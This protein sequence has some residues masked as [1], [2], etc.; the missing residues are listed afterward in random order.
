MS[1]RP[2]LSRELV[3]SIVLADGTGI[4][5]PPVETL[6]LPEKVVQFGTG[7]FLRGFAEYFIDEANRRGMFGGSVVAVS[8]TG[9][10]RDALL[11]EQ[12]G[13]YT[14]AIQGVEGSTS[15]QRY[16]IIGSLSRAVSARDDWSA[17]LELARSPDTQLV[18]SNSTEVGIVLDESDTFDANPP[19]SFPGK[20]TRFLAERARTFDYDERRGL[21]VLPCELIEDNGDVLRAIVAKLARRWS[22]GARFEQWLRG[23]VVFC[24]T[25]VDRIVPGVV[26][27]RESDRIGRLFGYRDG[28]ITACE[29]YALFAIQGDDRLRARLGFA[30]A[31][32]RIVVVPDIGPYRERKVRVLNGAHTISVPVAL[33]SGL[34]TVRDAVEDERVG[35]FIRRVVLDDIV[36]SLDAPG[37]EEFA[38]EVLERFANPYIRHSLID[39]TLYGTTKMRVRVVPSIVDYYRRVGRAPASLAFGFAAYI[40]FMRG[41]VHAERRTAGLAVPE[42]ND[43]QAIRDAWLDADPHSDASITEVAHRVCGNQNVWGADLSSLNGFADVVADHLVRIVRQGIQPALDVHLTEPATT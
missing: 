26:G 18:I 2:R 7:A 9:S 30:D 28:L 19:R 40:A 41:E 35:R 36:P 42:D 31:D 22:L 4:E 3:A 14:L 16:R 37:A 13:L 43:G 38:N 20:L 27:N 25:L 6:E 17:V 10:Q 8:S 23:S 1:A 12:D 34:E 15:R 39:I 11:N 21:V 29:S 24:N 5:V 33:L 32:P